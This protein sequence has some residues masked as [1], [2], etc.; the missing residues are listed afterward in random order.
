MTF[1]FYLTPFQLG[2][3]PE[4]AEITTLPLLIISDLV[5]YLFSIKINACW[6]RGVYLLSGGSIRPCRDKET[7]AVCMKD[8]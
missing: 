4:V 1:F 3:V 6:N 2:F 5:F 7:P 8:S